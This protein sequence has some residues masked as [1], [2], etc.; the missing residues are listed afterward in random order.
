MA[1][2]K[3]WAI[4]F[5]NDHE[6]HTDFA[7]NILQGKTPEDLAYLKN[8]SGVFFSNDTLEKY[9]AEE[10]YH[11]DFSLTK[12]N[13]RSIQTFSSGEQRKAL[14]SYLLSKNP[15]FIIVDHLFDMLDI[16][17]QKAIKNKLHVI[18]AHTS[19]L[20][21]AN[22]KNSILSFIT[23][24]MVFSN[25]KIIYAG[26][27]KDLKE[28]YVPKKSSSFQTNLPKP[29]NQAFQVKNPLVKFKN[30]CVK[31][32]ERVIVKNINWTIK[33]NEFWQLK[34]PNGAG[35]TTLLSLITGDNPKAYNQELYLFG[36]RRGSGESIWDIKRN[37]GYIT[38]SMI[39]LFRGWNTVEKMIISGLVDSIGLY[40]KPTELERRKAD[41]WLAL[42]DMADAKHK[43]FSTLNETKKRMI[44]I[45]RAMIKHPPLLILDEPS[46]GL[47]DGNAAL[48]SALI[49]KIYQEGQTSII[50]VSHR[51]E[52]G[53]KPKLIFELIP[54]EYGSEGRLKTEIYDH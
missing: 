22:R 50:Y 28:W 53:L 52:P 9:I 33:K 12:T 42:L 51:N 18:S 8:K 2:K 44:L 41:E 13:N 45:A 19:I 23:N 38:P 21:I 11:D 46:Q 5:F 26:K 54:D 17:S 30:V 31:Y 27:I 25:D 29:L 15:E 10:K 1:I 24:V 35:K 6:N 43:R 49:N 32:G 34:G 39:S 47:N 37:I 48:L 36:Q 14:F 16:S 40:K 7:K 3:H 4:I 20:Q